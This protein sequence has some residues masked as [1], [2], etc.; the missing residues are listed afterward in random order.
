MSTGAADPTQSGD[1]GPEAPQR[2]QGL[3]AWQG[4]QLP[5]WLP[6]QP[7]SLPGFRRAGSRL[8]AALWPRACLLC[9]EACGDSALCQPCRLALPGAGRPRCPVCAAALPRTG[10]DHEGPCRGSE[11]MEEAS[12]RDGG[13]G[14]GG[15]GDGGARDGKAGGCKAGD[16]K[17]GRACDQPLAPAASRPG[18][19][20]CHRLQPLFAATIAAA[21]YRPPLAEAITALKFG[22]QLGLASGLGRLLAEQLSTQPGGQGTALQAGDAAAEILI[23]TPRDQALAVDTLIPIPLAPT[24]LADRGFN[25][26]EAIARALIR[27]WPGRQP[28][29]APGWLTRARDTPRQ[30][31]LGASDRLDNIAASFIAAPAVAGRR[32][33]LVDDVMTTGATLNA[34]TRALLASGAASVVAFV[35]ARTP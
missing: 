16:G 11:D 20:D 1:P 6:D 9:E 2:R 8:A 32:L 25:Q 28:A 30:S 4:R 22:R 31:A 7:A 10:G 15:V 34:A 14:D 21:D 3:Q 29:L 13:V 24:R 18:C 26:A 23:P 35:V 27:H 12:G 17:A 19:A 5:Q 33:G